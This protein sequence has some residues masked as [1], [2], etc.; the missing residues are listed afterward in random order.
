M[1]GAVR[2]G[3]AFR[4][5]YVEV[6]MLMMLSKEGMPKYVGLGSCRSRKSVKTWICGVS[7]TSIIVSFEECHVTYLI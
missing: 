4:V 7:F 5:G 1:I 6:A 2:V 3:V